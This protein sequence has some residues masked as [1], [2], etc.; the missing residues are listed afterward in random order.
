[1]PLVFERFW[2][3]GKND[4]RGLG[5][6]LYISSHIA[7]LHGGRIL[8]DTIAQHGTTMLVTFPAGGSG[9]H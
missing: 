9:A 2:Q 8:V 3:V 5:L 6:G 7:E 4:K 1:M